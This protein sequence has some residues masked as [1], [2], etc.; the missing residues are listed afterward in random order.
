MTHIF[1]NIP[2]SDLDRAKAFYTSL[3]AT[4]NPDFT[5]DNGS[6][7]VWGD[8]IYFMVLTREFFATFTDKQVCDPK[9]HAM[10]LLSVSRD[11]RE[12][13]DAIVEAGIAAGGRQLGEPTDYGFMYSRALEDPDGNGIDFLYLVPQDEL[14]SAEPATAG[15]QA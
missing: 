1:V 8:N 11:S 10:A 15:A 13:V 5:D 7:V 3:G 2:T 14:A 6:C 12:A 4:L 9:T